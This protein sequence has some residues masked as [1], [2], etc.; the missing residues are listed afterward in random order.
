MVLDGVLI[1]LTAP[2]PGATPGAS[3]PGTNEGVLLS[4]LGVKGGGLL[5]G[6]NP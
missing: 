3:L 5:M 1:E 2:T 4:N 6:L